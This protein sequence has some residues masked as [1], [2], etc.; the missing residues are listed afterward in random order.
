MSLLS[1]RPILQPFQRLIWVS[2]F[3]DGYGSDKAEAIDL[4]LI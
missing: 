1:L 3:S 2:E 4:E